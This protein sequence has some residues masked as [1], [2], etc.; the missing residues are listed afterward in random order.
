M[1]IAIVDIHDITR[2]KLVTRIP[3]KGRGDGVIVK[4]RLP[5][6]MAAELKM[7]P[8]KMIRSTA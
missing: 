6:N 3:L 1:N 5:V 7:C 4:N 8:M 2:P